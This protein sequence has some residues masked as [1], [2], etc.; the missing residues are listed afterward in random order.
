M[1]ERIPSITGTANEDAPSSSVPDWENYRYKVI[2]QHEDNRWYISKMVKDGK[3]EEA[4][5]NATPDMSLEPIKAG[6]TPTPFIVLPNVDIK[7][8]STT[9]SGD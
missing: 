9:S 8:S 6:V 3:A 5:P 2:C 7:G 4:K 1:T